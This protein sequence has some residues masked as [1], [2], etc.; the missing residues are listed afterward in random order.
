MKKKLFT[1]ALA[2][3][4]LL[5]VVP[6]AAFA[7]SDKGGFT[8]NQ[9]TGTTQ[10]VYGGQ[11]WYV[12][13]YNGTGVASESGS[14]TLLAKDN[15]KADV[16]FDD[17]Y[18]DYADSNLKIEIDKLAELSSAGHGG[19]FTQ[20]EQNAIKKV[21]LTGGSANNAQGG[22]CGA[23][24]ENA[25][26]WP[27][28][29]AE[30]N[31]VTQDL[32]KASYHWWLRSPGVNDIVAAYVNI[33]GPVTPFGNGTDFAFGVRPALKLNLSSVL[34]ASA[35]AGGKSGTAGANLSATQTATGAQ[36]LT[37]V[38]NGHTLTAATT[39][40]TLT[41]DS[42]ITVNY[43]GANT[44]SGVDLA[45]MITYD[46]GAVTYYGTLAEDLSA[47]SGTASVRLP[48]DFNSA[49]MDLKLFTET[50]NGDNLTDYASA[51][52][53]VIPTSGTV[54]IKGTDFKVNTTD[55]T[56]ISF[57]GT[58]W[59]V[60][61][62][63]GE[64]GVAT[65]N[66]SMT[67]LAKDFIGS[68]VQFNSTIPYSNE[69]K[70]NNLNNIMDGYA[71]VKADGN[72]GLFTQAEQN[73]LNKR[74]LTGGAPSNAQGGMA[75]ANVADAVLWPLDVA[76]ANLVNSE[77]RKTGNFWW[78]RS[79]G[80]LNVFAAFVNSNGYVSPLGLNVN[81]N[82]Y[83]VRPAFKLNLSS[84]LFASAAVGGKS[85]QPTGTDA[86]G[87]NAAPT[88]KLR[89][90][91]DAIL[92]S[93]NASI[94][95]SDGNVTYTA[96]AGSV[97][98]AEMTAG[99]KT[100]VARKNI[101]AAA[102]GATL[103]LRTITGL[104]L[105]AVSG[106]VWIEKMEDVANNKG[107]IYA[108]EPENVS[109]TIVNTYPL[110]VSSGSGSGS[111]AKDASVTITADAPQTGKRF[112]EW[113]G[114]DGLTF[115]GGTC[116]TSATAT[117]TMPA[118][119]VTVSATYEN[120]PAS[121]SGGSSS[122]DGSSSIGRSTDSI[123][124]IQAEGTLYSN[125]MVN[126]LTNSKTGASNE[127]VDEKTYNE[128]KVSVDG[129]FTVIGAYEIKCASY[130]GSLTLSFPVD[131]K[132]NS[133][134]FIVKHKTSAGKINTYT[135]TV[136]DGKVV[137]TVPSLSPFMIAIKSLQ[138]KPKDGVW[139]NPF[140]DIR[141]T[142]WFYEKVALANQLGLMQGTSA[143]TF[144]PN[145]STTR[146][147]IVTMLYNMAGKPE[148]QASGAQWYAKGSAW[149]MTKG[150]SDG[151]DMNG[152]IT[153]EQLVTM[154]W[155]NAGSPAVT[156]DSRLSTFSDA[157]TISDYAKQAFAWAIK[158][159]MI[160]GKG[161]DILDPRGNASRAEAATMMIHYLNAMKK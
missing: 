158:Q 91:D 121:P 115:T 104:P 126:R 49:T 86:F 110:T 87:E 92:S 41:A 140:I 98:V 21:T 145:S 67:L 139:V 35:A 45:A 131:A 114:A 149:A 11:S 155:R 123:T 71:L 125:I 9:A 6:Q 156:D 153:R 37:I 78:L 50:I 46:T 66:G 127:V 5:S 27:L 120:I 70:N 81:I 89:F 75:G 64:A 18:N 84:V 69:Y 30:A 59:R 36:K 99:G 38:D 148:V 82:F 135:G 72:S 151:S 138:E 55:A 8:V 34:F 85:I 63:N 77:L 15:L 33:S 22:M 26:L 7:V 19:L 152:G 136:K 122:G 4:M 143:T 10:I 124:G 146:G 56:T 80:E 90:Q 108:I 58:D 100:Y 107:L 142:D 88:Q 25:I 32:R 116:K 17:T 54:S 93:S 97:L 31:E 119:P 13:G 60:I 23:D 101:D 157:G 28:D 117:F 105:G 134:E 150:I 79:P 39:T 2:L 113:T 94:S 24:V 128:L 48:A 47:A 160:Q 74:N 133:Q 52:V 51:P 102:S 83:D 1:M 159:G 14:M 43:T 73:A 3:C 106:K 42:T 12:I 61:G 154:L 40:N 65:E 111:Y 16:K 20:A 129:G 147:M 109:Y 103:D 130:N 118:S 95:A 76:E 57:G 53:T 96:P 132:Y 137:I 141:G 62:A 44:G 68:S 112:K 161:N 29:V 144:D